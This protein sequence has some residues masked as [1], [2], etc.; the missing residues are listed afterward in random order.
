[1][2]RFNPWVQVFKPQ[3]SAIAR[4]ICFPFAGGGAQSFN[5]WPAHL[6]DGIELLAVQL[7]GRETR[8]RETPLSD[9]SCLLDAMLPEIQG[10][11]DRPFILY[12]HSMGALIAYEFARRMQ[13]L[14]LA[15]ECLMVSARVAP[16]RR[17]PREPIN[18]LPQAEFVE[19]LR[20]LNGTPEEVLGNEDLMALIVPMLRADFMLNEEYVYAA[21]PRLDCDILAFG[22]LADLETERQGMDD[23]REVTDGEFGLRMVPGGHFFIQTAQTLF[24]RMLSIEIYQRTKH[25]RPLQSFA[26]AGG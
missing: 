10:Y 12:G 8:M 15:P 6:P 25:L 9:V 2:R 22:G 5:K 17:P 23:W 11:L 7:P 13:R 20:Q 19:A 24:L 26:S 18:K 16:H 21:E 3:E 1:M 4:L 14:S